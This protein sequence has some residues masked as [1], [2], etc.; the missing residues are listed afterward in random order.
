MESHQ[1]PRM[2]QGIKLRT[3][4]DTI[5]MFGKGITFQHSVPPTHGNILALNV[6]HLRT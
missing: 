2:P 5:T 1:E 4:S 6:D 3:E